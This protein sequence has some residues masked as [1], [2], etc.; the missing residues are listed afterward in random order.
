MRINQIGDP[1]LRKV[2]RPVEHSEINST[3]IKN[4][5][6]KMKEILNGI[7]AISN[8]NG[9]AIAAPQVGHSV[10]IILLRL[11][12][13]F[14][15]MINPTFTQISDETFE[16]EEECFSFYHLRGL[17]TRYSK[18]RV[19]YLDENAQTTSVL[20]EG[21]DAGIA[22]HEVDHLDGIFFLDRLKNKN[23][24]MSVDFMLRDNPQRLSVV[25][26]M[27]NYMVGY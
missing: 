21:E 6:I 2:C 16:L 26:K 25:R 13:Q 12:E 3:E 22:Q 4:T 18:I 1:I 19:D 8:E 20:L 11:K 14:I 24:V 5:I 27:I 23:T 9:N 17:V 7:K 10:R 15:P